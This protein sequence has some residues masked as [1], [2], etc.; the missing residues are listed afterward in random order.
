MNK[1]VLQSQV[2]HLKSKGTF[3]S[4]KYIS[5]TLKFELYQYEQQYFYIRYEQQVMFAPT[6]VHQLPEQQAK[7]WLQ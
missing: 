3:L 2:E 1:A 6:E 5:P 7:E 4:E